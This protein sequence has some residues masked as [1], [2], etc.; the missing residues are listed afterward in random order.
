VAGAFRLRVTYLRKLN[1]SFL[2]AGMHPIWELTLQNEGPRAAA[3]LLLRL[4]L[5]DDLGTGTGPLDTGPVRL[6]DLAP[7]T[8]LAV[9]TS[10]LPWVRRDVEAA[11]RLDGPRH[12]HWHL[13][14][15]GHTVQL[16]VEVL[17]PD[18]WCAG[19]GWDGRQFFLDPGVEVAEA[20]WGLA[21]AAAVAPT[22]RERDWAGPWALPAATAA[23]VLP[24]APRVT[25]IKQHAAGMLDIIVG[26]RLVPLEEWVAGDAD[27]KTAV[28][29]AAFV[30]L[31][32][33]Y[34]RAFHDI[35]KFSMERLSQR[36]RLPEEA[37]G[38]GADADYAPFQ[39]RP[40]RE[41]QAHPGGSGATCVDY[42]LLFCGV[43]EAC[44]LE[45]LFVLV[46]CGGVCH[47]LVGCWLRPPGADG[48]RAPLLTDPAPVSRWLARKGTLLVVDVTE[49][50]RGRSFAE[51]CALGEGRLGRALPAAGARPPGAPRTAP[52]VPS[53]PEQ[54]CYA[55]DLRAARARHRIPPLPCRPAAGPG[56]PVRPP[57]Y[58]H[59][60]RP[61]SE[62]QDRP[63]LE[64][65]RSFWRRPR[66][67]VLGVVG[68]GGAG[69]TALLER[70]LAELPRTWRAPE[71]V[72]KRPDLPAPDGLFV[73]SFY[74]SAD[75]AEFARQLA[76]YCRR[77]A[78]RGGG[79]PDTGRPPRRAAAAGPAALADALDAMAADGPGRLLLVLDGLERVQKDRNV[80][81]QL[82]DDAAAVKALLRWAAGG[83][84]AAWVLATS[85][86]PLT[87]LADW[88][89]KAYHVLSVDELGPDAAR[90]L[91]RACG[92]RGDAGQLDGLAQEFG[93][94]ALTLEHLGRT[95]TQFFDGDP[96]Q[97]RNLPPPG[98]GEGPPELEIQ[99]Q[100]LA[101]ILRF[102]EGHLSP[103][104][105]GVL[106][107][108]SAWSGPVDEGAIGATATALHTKIPDV[109]GATG[110]RLRESLARLTDLRFLQAHPGE[111]AKSYSAHPFISQYFYRALKEDALLAH[112]GAREY[113]ERQIG[114]DS[115]QQEVRGAVR[116]RGATTLA[117]S[118]FPWPIDPAVRD[119]LE[120]L[121]YHLLRANRPEE[122]YRLYRDR[123]GGYSFL[124]EVLGDHARG[125]R[126]VALFLLHAPAAPVPSPPPRW[127]RDLRVDHERYL[128]ALA[129]QAPPPGPPA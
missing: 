99:A 23:L 1:W 86:L 54:F 57:R 73:W 66:G 120:N 64:A 92:V 36:V 81:G 25:R 114:P 29:Q 84:G 129:A 119:L 69:K 67:G 95:L 26:R 18:E 70:F 87:D 65:V 100:R 79:R 113:L 35:E 28:V 115:L 101:R 83:A 37:V 19:V 80:L 71:A 77:P 103:V 2:Q 31:A 110:Y 32:D 85:R 3:D 52:P 50:A 56:R 63:E 108:V 107:A 46:G 48:D 30:A 9:D 13:Q 91:L 45:P 93:R 55:L 111:S 121:I 106:M 39:P 33:L 74:E 104:D 126:I 94:H 82:T 22:Y 123:L 7:G 4:H 41:G 24:A 21:G 49:F 78:V 88:R 34:P 68:I 40:P 42:A 89:G 125:E 122:A 62:F 51:A 16:P 97:A 6:D 15:A 60:L 61:A 105:L 76:D 90:A 124:G 17:A 20:D 96:A 112:E 109:G 12:T 58:A 27:Q 44:G 127:L 38:G 10:R 59:Y 118:Q 8:T 98:E 53:G 5:G 116:T 117:P 72:R 75:C 11:L 102:I 128:E 14:V 43:L 47:A